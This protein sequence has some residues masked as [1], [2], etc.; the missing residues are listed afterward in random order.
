MPVPVA[1]VAADGAGGGHAAVEVR[2]DGQV[3]PAAA[4]PDG[5]VVIELPRHA[6][7][8]TWLVEIISSRSRE[9]GAA[10][11]GG[12]AM[13]VHAVD[14]AP[15]IFPAGTL[16]RRFYWELLLE[17]DE[18]AIGSPARWTS[19]QRWEWGA[20]GLRRVPVVSREVLA[21]WLAASA[22]GSAQAPPPTRL[23]AD[24]PDV[25]SRIVYAGVGTPG[26]GRIWVVPTWLLVLVVSG[27][28][29]AI[30]L[31]LVYRWAARLV[32]AGLAVAAVASIAAAAFPELAALLA[33]AAVPGIA[34]TLLA[35][36]LRT[37]LEPR[38]PRL[39]PA[40][41]A[42]SSLTRAASLP[43]LII[44]SSSTRL[45]ESRPAAGHQPP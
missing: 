31:V 45:H 25:G 20:I 7:S 8:R 35:A 28:V 3:L 13:P 12:V 2:L 9:Q 16:Q 41:A 34:L 10:A 18:H 6:G 36:A 32:P 33:Q 21:A 17:P 15:A 43:S 40:V 42:S 14:L 22:A 38:K 30:G 26:E 5:R 4:A 27:P 39:S 11:W 29:L 1:A 19:Q 24:V 44:A 37:A 23:P